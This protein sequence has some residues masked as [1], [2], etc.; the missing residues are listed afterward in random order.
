MLSRPW[1]FE[2]AWV[3][4]LWQTDALVPVLVLPGLWWLGRRWGRAAL[5]PASALLLHPLAMALLA[6]Y[7]GPDF[8]E[9]RYSIHLLPL[10]IVAAVAALT[11]AVSRVPAGGARGAGWRPLAGWVGAGALLVGALVTLPPAASRYG[12]GVQNID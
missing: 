2:S 3:R 12:W 4:W 7:R 6:P 5:L 10:A 8:Q 9:G 1:Q 11:P